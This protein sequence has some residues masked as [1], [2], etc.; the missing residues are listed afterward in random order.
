MLPALRLQQTLSDPGS[1]QV[2]ISQC[3]F[4]FLEGCFPQLPN[5]E[6]CLIMNNSLL[7]VRPTL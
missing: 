6:V 2:L 3:H 1:G 7:L 5:K 4:W